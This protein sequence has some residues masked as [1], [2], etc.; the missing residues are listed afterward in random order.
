MKGKR[1]EEEGKRRRDGGR[2]WRSSLSLAGGTVWAPLTIGKEAS[3]V[4]YCT[5]TFVTGVQKIF[6]E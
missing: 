6:Q 2:N 4:L 3:G 5:A 1:E